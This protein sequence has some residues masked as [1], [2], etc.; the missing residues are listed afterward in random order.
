MFQKK[1]N[2]SENQNTQVIFFPPEDHVVYEIMW[3]NIVEPERLQLKIWRMRILC[4]I[5]KATNTNT[6]YVIFIDFTLQQW[7]HERL[8]LL[9]YTYIARLVKLCR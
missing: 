3:K 9:R 8:S 1:K 5:P 4:W 2:C 7:L 6:E